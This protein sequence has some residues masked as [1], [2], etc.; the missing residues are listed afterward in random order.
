MAIIQTYLKIA[1]AFIL[2]LSQIISPIFLSLNEKK[3]FEDWSADQAWTDDYAVTLEKKPGKDFVL[4]N[5]ADIQLNA[6]GS[7]GHAGDLYKQIVNSLVEELDPDLITLSGDNAWDFMAYLELV[8]YIDSLNIPWAAVMGNHDGQGLANEFCAAY[9]LANAKNSL[10]KYGPKDMGYGNYIINV[11]ENGKIIHTIFMMDTHSNAKDTEAGK[12]NYAPDGKNDYDHLWA[13]QLEWY[14]WAVNG[15]TASAGHTVESTVITHIPCYEY[16][17]AFAEAQYDEA[18]DSFINPEYT[19][20]SYGHIEEGIYSAE[21]NNGFFA[22]C[23]EL[24]STKNMI[25][26]HDHINNF[27]ILYQGIR[28]SYSLKCGSGCYWNPKMSGGSTITINSDGVGTF[29]H[30]YT[31]FE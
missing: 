24:G 25:A 20:T 18:T 6:D 1:M 27:S 30:H 8:K 9:Y 29:A 3:Y 16:R 12:I 22:L 26:G 14:K 10:F 17:T 4:L 21:G 15:I 31:N 7:Y 28:L 2:S 5:L 23:K 11:T 13:N 19:N